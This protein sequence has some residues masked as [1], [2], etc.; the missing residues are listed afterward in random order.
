[1][2]HET[3]SHALQAKAASAQDAGP[4]C[5]PQQGVAQQSDKQ[6]GSAHDGHHSGSSSGIDANEQTP[7]VGGQAEAQTE[8]QPPDAEGQAEREP[9][10]NALSD[11][12]GSR[13]EGS[14]LEAAWAGWQA[15][16]ELL[17]VQR[18]WWVKLHFR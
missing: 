15:F 2:L 14:E 11:Q 4:A 5:S 13:G 3:L 9:E 18:C 17:P 6:P 10:G 1:M 8:R 16:Q 7:E 12:Q